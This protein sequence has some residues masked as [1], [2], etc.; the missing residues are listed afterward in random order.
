[1]NTSQSIC[2]KTYF[3]GL[4]ECTLVV[5]TRVETVVLEKALISN[6]CTPEQVNV[7]VGE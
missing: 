2:A 4:L 7:K 5:S 1:M 6:H 3:A